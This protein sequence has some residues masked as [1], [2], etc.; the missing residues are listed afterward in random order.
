MNVDFTELVRQDE[1]SEHEGHHS[2]ETGHSE[3]RANYHY[4]CQEPEALKIVVVQLMAAF[5]GVETLSAQWISPT[6]QGAVDLTMQSNRIII[7]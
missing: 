5:S 3:I 6:H 4:R 2:V 1:H 7:E